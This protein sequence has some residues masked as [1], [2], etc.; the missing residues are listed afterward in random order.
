M[1]SLFDRTARRKKTLACSS[2]PCASHHFASAMNT[3][4]IFVSISITLLHNEFS[5]RLALR[6]RIVL[7]SDE[8]S[9]LAQSCLVENRSSCAVLR[10]HYQMPIEPLRKDLSVSKF[11]VLWSLEPALLGPQAVKAVLAMPDYASKL[12]NQGK[13]DERYHIVGRHGGAWIYDVAS[14]EELDR[15]LALS[16]VYNFSRYEVYPLAEMTPAGPEQ[17]ETDSGQNQSVS[18]FQG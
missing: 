13:L 6:L 1:R 5:I 4:N 11:L 17:S 8:A 10:Y 2:S 14:N 15:L 7:T 3:S 18:S 16:P 9:Y 12:V